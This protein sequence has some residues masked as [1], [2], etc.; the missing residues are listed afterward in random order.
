MR[1]TSVMKTIHSANQPQKKM[2][3]RLPMEYGFTRLAENQ[4]PTPVSAPTVVVTM[5]QKNSSR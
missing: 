5:K 2:R 4:M 3:M 1:Q